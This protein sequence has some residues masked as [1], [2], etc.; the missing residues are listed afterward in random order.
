MHFRGRGCFRVIHSGWLLSASLWAGGVPGQ[1]WP[2]LSHV[3]LTGEGTLASNDTPAAVGRIGLKRVGVADYVRNDVELGGCALL[4]GLAPE[5]AERLL[6]AAVARRFPDGAHLFRQ[7]EAGQSL[8]LVLSGE[9]HV[10]AVREG[11]SVEV[12]SAR[13]G[14]VF[15]EAEWV[16]GAAQRTQSAVARGG[17]AVAELPVA[18]VE[19]AARAAPTLDAW[20]RSLHAGRQSAQDEMSDFL[21]RW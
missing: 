11:E 18:A 20:L 3:T 15:G 8:F 4:K 14:D 21:N 6:S 7:G 12:A 10:Q 13:K 1:P 5:V 16:T 17:V 19:E 2:T 9:A